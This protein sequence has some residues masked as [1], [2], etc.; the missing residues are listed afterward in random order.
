[1]ISDGTAKKTTRYRSGGPPFVFLLLFF[2][3]PA[4]IVVVASFMVPGEFGG[5]APLF[6][7]RGN[8]DTG[9]TAENYAVF[10]GDW[11]Y[12]QIFAKSFGVAALTTLICLVA[13][14]P[15]AMLIARMPKKRIKQLGLAGKG[16]VR[17]NKAGCLD[18]C[19]EGPVLVVYP[20]EIWYT[21]VDREDIDE[22][23]DSHLVNGR[24]VERLRI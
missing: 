10:F 23:I 3:L 22:I 2:A 9:L 1:M 17:I 19:E 7:L 11:V 21:Y 16:A 20:E 14:Y 8:E 18:R 15:L 24:I 13:G 6:P 4:L 5:L 12:V